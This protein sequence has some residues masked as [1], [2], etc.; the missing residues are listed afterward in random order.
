[1]TTAFGRQ[2]RWLPLWFFSKYTYIAHQ[3]DRIQGSKTEIV[4]ELLKQHYFANWVGMAGQ[5]RL[6]DVSYTYCA[7][8]ISYRWPDGTLS[9]VLI[10]MCLQGKI[11]VLNS[12][13]KTGPSP[14][15]RDRLL[16]RVPTTAT[17]RPGSR[18]EGVCEQCDDVA[19]GDTVARCRAHSGSGSDEPTMS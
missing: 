11:E 2:G 7:K 15:S 9:S 10:N 4:A 16:V 17:C 5:I 14:E 19:V 13:R 8:T 6:S 3:L 1:M 12:G 18:R